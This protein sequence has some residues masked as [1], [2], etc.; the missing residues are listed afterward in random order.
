ME[1]FSF[2]IPGSVGL[3]VTLTEL[4]DGSVRF[5]LEN[6]G[7]QVAD[8][9]GLFFDFNDP[10]LLSSLSVEGSQVSEASFEDDSVRNLGDG[11]NMNGEGVFDIGV[12]FGTAGIGY[13]DIFSTSFTLSSSAG[14]LSLEAFANVEFGVRYTSVGTED[15]VREDSLKLVA[16]S[17]DYV[18]P[19]PLDPPIIIG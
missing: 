19:D 15:G 4:E 17:P 3:Q 2:L 1:S 18:P 10:D 7:D 16:L 5:D 8:L 6:Q 9:R 12:S 14:P 13:D 11:V